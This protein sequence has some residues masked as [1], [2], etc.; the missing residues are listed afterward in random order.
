MGKDKEF[1][2]QT[3]IEDSGALNYENYY[4]N[5]RH[6]TKQ[7]KVFKE[8]VIE[9]GECDESDYLTQH[10]DT[11]QKEIDELMELFR[12]KITKREK[13]IVYIP[14]DTV[15]ALNYMG[16]LINDDIDKNLD[17]IRNIMNALEYKTGDTQEDKN[18]I[19]YYQKLVNHFKTRVDDVKEP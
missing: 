6:K 14:M 18:Q 8:K 19:S 7:I 16:Y 1:F 9:L 17:D 13:R 4:T 12:G 5:I 3:I 10:C 2:I 11:L 15:H